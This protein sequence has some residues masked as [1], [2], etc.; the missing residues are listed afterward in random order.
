MSY[1]AA[2]N[3]MAIDQQLFKGDA[4][5]PG[6]WKSDTSILGKVPAT[7]ELMSGH[8]HNGN[9]APLNSLYSHCA[10]ARE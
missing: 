2:I 10:R 5:V 6:H 9:A 4:I 3:E 7:G 1:P 8:S